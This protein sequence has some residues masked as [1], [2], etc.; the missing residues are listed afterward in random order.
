MLY[1][2]DEGGDMTSQVRFCMMGVL[3]VLAVL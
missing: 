1:H 2:L 3:D